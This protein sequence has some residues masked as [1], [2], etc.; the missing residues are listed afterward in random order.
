MAPDGRHLPPLDRQPRGE[1][2][3]ACR[4][5]RFFARRERDRLQEDRDRFED[6]GLRCRTL[7]RGRLAARHFS[8]RLGGLGRL[9]TR[10]RGWNRLGPRCRPRS[11]EQGE[12]LIQQIAVFLGLRPEQAQGEAEALC[13]I[14]P[15]SRGEDLDGQAVVAQ[16]DRDSAAAQEI[17][18]VE[19]PRV[20]ACHGG[21]LCLLQVA[22]GLAVRLRLRERAEIGEVR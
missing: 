16:A 21:L 2:V 19:Q 6:L 15:D 14:E 3:D 17:E 12:R 7:V 22:Q 9:R 8:R 20:H 18:D 13:A 1:Q 4:L 5:R 10:G 11:R